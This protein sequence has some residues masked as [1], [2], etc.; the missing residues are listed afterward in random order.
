MPI[1]LG[2]NVNIG[3]GVEAVRGTAVSPSAFIP[4]RTPSGIKPLVE[5]VLLKETRKSRAGSYGREITHIRAEGDLE[6]NVRSKS[7]GYLL[8]SLIGS[9]S[10]DP[11]AGAYNHTFIPDVDDIQQPALSLY[12]AQEGQQHYIYPNGVVRSIEFRTPVDDLVNATAS[13][14][15]IKENAVASIDEASVTWDDGD[16]AFRPYNVTIKKAANV[17]GLGAAT[18]L[19]VKEFAMTI[20]NNAR[21]DINLGNINASDVYGLLFDV[22]GNL[23]IDYSD[24][25][26]HDFY[27][28]GDYFAMQ[29]TFSRPDVTIGSTS[30]S[31][32]FTLPKVSVENWTPD[33]PIDEVVRNGID[34]TAHYDATETKIIQAVLTNDVADYDPITS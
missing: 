18:A 17:A 2:E 28:D 16:K 12:L 21:A 33:R 15:A 4:A 13:F 32:Q 5:S 20:T 29:V 25:T 10:S 7:I 19:P 31:L 14:I 11:S 26:W 8:K 24:E 22:S 34:F 30:P 9:P 6:F 3:V 1:L 27:T 23:V